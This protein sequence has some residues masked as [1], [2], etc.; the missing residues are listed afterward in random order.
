MW[1]EIEHS[2]AFLVEGKR[3]ESLEQEH[4]A[5]KLLLMIVS[6]LF[7]VMTTIGGFTAAHLINQSDELSVR[8]TVVQTQL[9]TQEVER[10]DAERRLRRIEGLLDDA[11]QERTR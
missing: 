6:A 4:L 8:M 1:C 10:Q 5:I 9:A 2:L 11:K 7:V 3:M